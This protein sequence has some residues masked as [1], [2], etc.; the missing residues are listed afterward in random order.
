M[1]LPPT[2]SFENRLT[3]HR[4]ARTIDIRFLGRGDTDHDVIVHL[5]NDGVVVAGDMVVHPFP[6]GFSTQADEWIAT[7]TKLSELEFSYL[8]PGHGD[9]QRGKTY[10]RRVIDLVK[11]VQTPGADLSAFEKEMAGNDPVLRYYFREYFVE[12]AVAEARK[13]VR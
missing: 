13:K 8:V 1:N 4:G 7:L 9:V 5:P 12:P 3:L 2:A 6:Y 11:A 10:L